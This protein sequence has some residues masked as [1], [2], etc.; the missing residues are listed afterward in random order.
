VRLT[1]IPAAATDPS[2]RVEVALV[3]DEIKLE[4]EEAKARI[5]E[6]PAGEAG[7]VRLG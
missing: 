7:S 5:I 2:E 3:R 1:I 4:D 6:M